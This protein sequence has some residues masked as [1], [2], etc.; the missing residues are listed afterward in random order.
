MKFGF[1]LKNITVGD[2]ATIGE[3]SINVQYNPGEM[4]GEYELLKRALKE[5]PEIVADL[6]TGAV[7]FDKMDQAFDGLTNAKRDENA[8]EETKQSAINKVMSVI[9][10]LRGM[11][12]PEEKKEDN[13]AV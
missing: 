5:V 9:S 2:K 7:A 13:K 8:T 4:V 6:G 12:Q 10:S 11:V 1:V 3:M